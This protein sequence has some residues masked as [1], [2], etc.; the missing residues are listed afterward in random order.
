MKRNLFYLVL[1]GIA[2]CSCEKNPDLN[3]LDS[4]FTGQKHTICPTVS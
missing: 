1:A 3:Q 2:L 4:D